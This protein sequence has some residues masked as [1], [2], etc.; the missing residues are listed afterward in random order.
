MPAPFDNT[1]SRARTVSTMTLIASVIASVLLSLHAFGAEPIVQST[2]ASP[3]PSLQG[4]V[5]QTPAMQLVTLAATPAYDTSRGPNSTDAVVLTYDDCPRSI[6]QFKA[7]INYAAE[8][9]IGLVLFPT[10]DCVKSYKRQGFGLVTYA[11]DRGIWVA[12]HSRSHP[13]LT[14]SKLSRADVVRQI[15]GTAVSNYG[16]PPYGGVNA[17]VR[18]AYASVSSYDRDGMRIWPWDVD[19]LDWQKLENGSRPSSALITKRA[20]K[21]ADEGETVLMHM[22]H[23]GFNAK[24]MKAI[25][26]G[27]AK[28]GLELCR[29]WHGEDREGV[30]EATGRV[31]PD[32][33][34]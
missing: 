8:H 5:I 22:Q 11:R 12:N 13:L 17:K 25:A 3:A 7:A 18:G 16:R 31:I 14:S 33:I 1:P 15:S 9:D 10:G 20:V 28:K 26:K 21:A 32:N 2:T 4:G 29:A 30:L 27:L 34:C 24:T 19:T 23:N 6:K